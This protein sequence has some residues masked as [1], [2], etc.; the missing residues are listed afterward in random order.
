MI[1][2]SFSFFEGDV[3]GSFYPSGSYQVEY[4]VVGGGGSSS[5][6]AGGGGGG[7]GFRTGFTNV[8]SGS[9]YTVTVGA[10]GIT[11]NSTSPG[12]NGSASLFGQIVAAG[13]GGGGGGLSGTGP[14]GKVGASGGG[15]HRATVGNV[16][17]LGN[18]PTNWPLVQGYNGGIGNSAG[19]SN[20]GGGGGAGQN[21]GNSAGN[22]GGAGGSGSLW[23]GTFY[24][25]GGGGGGAT[26]TSGSGGPGGGGN[27]GINLG[28]GASGSANTG[29]GG[30]GG[31]N[32]TSIV[33]AAGGSGIV[34]IKYPG[35]QIGTGGT[36]TTS[37][38]FTVHTFLSSSVY[39]A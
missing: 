26:A 4:L 5:C 31:G 10:G 28:S 9:I 14:N 36:V 18:I 12:N 13:G 2:S 17:I 3:T 24:A 37:G 7:G 23:Y 1:Y 39:N 6:N 22:Q 21:G 27:G 35:S 34:I 38:S 33:G 25:G 32:G 20:A 30:G 19:S 29:G 16:P 8:I 15:Q 11:P